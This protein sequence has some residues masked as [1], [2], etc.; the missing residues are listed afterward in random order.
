MNLANT[1]H[2]YGAQLQ[3]LMVP[4]RRYQ[5]EVLYTD[6]GYTY[7]GFAGCCYTYTHHGL[8]M[9]CYGSLHL[10]REQF[11][12]VSAMLAVLTIPTL[13]CYGYTGPRAEWRDPPPREL[14][15]MGRQRARAGR[16]HRDRAHPLRKLPGGRRLLTLT[17]TFTLAFTLVLALALALALTL[18]HTPTLAPALSL[19]LARTLYQEDAVF[20]L[21]P[22]DALPWEFSI[23][24]DESRTT[25]IELTEAD[26]QPWCAWGV[27]NA[28]QDVCCPRACGLCLASPHC[29][30]L[31][32]GT[33]A[34]TQ[35]PA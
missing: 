32:A 15:A 16:F 8:A 34:L 31:P 10:V 19:A 28:A 6:Y 33:T 7:H 11:F 4:N 20:G 27:Q 24:N 25:A 18:A 30:L 26:L 5:F 23:T 29:S 1:P 12:P 35:A 13:A 21:R 9:A 2:F 17:R 22:Y 3:W 14:R